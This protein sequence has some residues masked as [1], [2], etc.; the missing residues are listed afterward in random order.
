MSEIGRDYRPAPGWVFLA[1]AFNAVIVVALGVLLLPAPWNYAGSLVVA[2]GTVAF[3]IPLRHL[4]FIWGALLPI[5]SVATLDPVIFDAIRFSIAAVVL[6]R[7]ARLP[8]NLWT[9]PA[10]RIAVTLAIVGVLVTVI[11]YS[12]PEQTAVNTGISM[13]IGSI[14]S[15]IILSRLDSPW[16]LFNG[17]LLG[18]AAS[19]AVLIAAAA[20][21]QTITPLAFAGYSRLSGLSPSATLVTYQMALG[22]VIALAGLARRKNRLSYALVGL[23]SLLALLLSGGRGGVVALLLVGI[24]AVRWRWVRIGPAILAAAAV[25]ALI[26]YASSR[27]LVLNTLL[28]LTADTG[29]TDPRATLLQGGLAA[30]QENPWIG[31][32]FE[33]FRSAY[34]AVPHFA[35]VTFFVIGGVACGIPIVWAFLVLLR[36]ILLVDPK[37]FGAEGQAGHMV[38]AVLIATIF[39]EPSGPFVGSAFQ[40]LLLLGLSLTEVRR[41]RN[42]PAVDAVHLVDA[43]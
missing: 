37:P 3:L 41:T 11:G 5:W 42:E 25:A 15:W 12:R 34:R 36:R 33:A 28:R 2:G 7:S 43:R 10:A 27:G 26:A 4:I 19:A 8:R 40:T 23:A 30:I 39:L 9:R 35:L 16:T 24:L 1:V 22:V 29:E 38:I 20:G 6:V 13:V 14:V 21:Y 31:V 18:T 17:Y 32:G